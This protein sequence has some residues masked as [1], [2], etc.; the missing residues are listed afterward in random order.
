MP[1]PKGKAGSSKGYNRNFRRR[2]APKSECD[3][4]PESA[5]DREPD[6]EEPEDNDSTRMRTKI[7][8]PVAMWVCKITLHGGLRGLLR[9]IRT[10]GIAT[11]NAVRE[12]NL[13]V[14]G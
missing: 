12:R 2:P 1:K 3:S 14:L 9:V 11:P 13:L 8:I 5:I 4:I 7:S 6:G 10:L